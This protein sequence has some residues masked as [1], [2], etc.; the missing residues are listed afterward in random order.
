MNSRGSRMRFQEKQSGLQPVSS[1]PQVE[2][3]VH[4]TEDLVDGG[5]GSGHEAVRWRF[6]ARVSRGPGADI[7]MAASIMN[8]FQSE[9]LVRLVWLKQSRTVL[10][11]EPFSLRSH[12]SLV[13]L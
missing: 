4:E 6:C 10:S 1:D 7:S 9:H 13:L 5:T 12:A 11:R 3:G 8:P 2:V